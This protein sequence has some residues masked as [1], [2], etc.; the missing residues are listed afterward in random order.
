MKQKNLIFFSV[1]T[2]FIFILVPC[3]S[4]INPTSQT[5][6]TSY[7][8]TGLEQ[9]GGCIY[10]RMLII[11]NVAYIIAGILS[12]QILNGKPVLYGFTQTFIRLIWSNGIWQIAR[13][14][15]EATGEDP[16]EPP[17]FSIS[18]FLN[19]SLNMKIRFLIIDILLVF[20][21]QT[22]IMAYRSNRL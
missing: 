18:G 14:A 15:A 19:A 12:R 20:L 6:F 2:T 9:N 7:I 10:T 22:F 11:W 8:T 21:L 5:E 3:T 1:F 17:I 4:A 13:L 16:G